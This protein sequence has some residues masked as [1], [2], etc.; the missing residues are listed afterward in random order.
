MIAPILPWIPGAGLEILRADATFM[1][2]AA[3]RVDSQPPGDVS[4]QYA[5]VWNAGNVPDDAGGVTW[6]PM[7]QVSAWAPLDMRTRDARGLVWE[8]AARALAVLA[9]IEQYRYRN[10]GFGTRAVGLD[11]HADDRSR[12]DSTVLVGAYAQV[13]LIGQA[14]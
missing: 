1:T 14:F 4:R 11:T 10:F 6:R 2:L 9:G 5:V 8:T 12:A 7:L 13:E 3:G